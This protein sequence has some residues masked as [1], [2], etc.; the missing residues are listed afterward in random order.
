MGGKI[1]KRSKKIIA[2]MLA[3]FAVLNLAGCSENREQGSDISSIDSQTESGSQSSDTNSGKDDSSS[4][5]SQSSIQSSDTS[6]KD[7]TSSSGESSEPA[8]DDSEPK[9]PYEKIEPRAINTLNSVKLFDAIS[10]DKKNAMFS[11]LSLNMAL[12]LVEAGADGDTKKQLDSYLQSENYADFAE[13]YL[14]FAKEYRNEEE[15]I[16]EWGKIPATALEIANSFWANKDLPFK[17]SYK[18]SVGQKF[19]AEIQ[20]ADFGNSGETVKKINSWVNEKTHEMIPSVIDNVDPQTAAILINTVY[21]ESEW[22]MSEWWIDENNKEDFKLLDGSVK[23]LPLMETY[24]SNYFENDKA[25]AFSRSYRN[26][27]EFIGI[28]PKNSGDFTLEGLDIPSLLESRKTEGYII[29]AAMPRLNFESQFA[30][31]DA[32]NAAGLSDIFDKSKA[33][34]SGITDAPFWIS[35]IIQKTKLELDEN[36]TRAAAVTAIEAGG[37]GGSKEPPKEVEVRLNRPFAFL[38]YDRMQDQILFM[39]KV[40]EP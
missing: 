22:L 33:D 31:N 30:L 26:G 20:N 34:F 25:T 29:S 38:I 1:M 15:Q 3:A 11:P 35:S 40:T 8:P 18:Q 13:Q 23:K 24:G 36:G 37:G 4:D 21:F 5:G 27:T 9:I 12:G 28:L 6:S 7:D 32:L 2:F 10:A 17:D 39:G 19:G 16:R 14:K